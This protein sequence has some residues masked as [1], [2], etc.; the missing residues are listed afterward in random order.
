MSVL[1]K[2]LPAIFIALITPAVDAETTPSPKVKA[3]Q[4]SIQCARDEPK[5]ASANQRRKVK[6]RSTNKNIVDNRNVATN[7]G[8]L[9][10][11]APASTSTAQPVE[12]VVAQSAAVAEA[13]STVTTTADTT[14]EAGNASS[15][16]AKTRVLT[17]SEIEA[18][19]AAGADPSTLVSPSAA[20]VGQGLGTA[21]GIGSTTTAPVLNTPSFGGSGGGS[22][23]AASR[24]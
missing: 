9:V 16:Q 22:G 5:S 23:S 21:D 10:C 14:K 1:K 12:P 7:T 15:K 2:A 17:P 3:T 13:P 24:S 20:G 8:G 19:V 6:K 11:A 4:P 18:A